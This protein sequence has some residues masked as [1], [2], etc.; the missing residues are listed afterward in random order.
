LHERPSSGA[1]EN[2]RQDD[3]QE[4][5]PRPDSCP[6][7]SGIEHISIH[8]SN[9][10]YSPQSRNR[11]SISSG[12]AKEHDRLLNDSTLDAD[13]RSDVQTPRSS[14]PAQATNQILPRHLSAVQARVKGTTPEKVHTIPQGPRH[15]SRY[16]IHKPQSGRVQAI[17][18]HASTAPSL[19][20]E[21]AAAPVHNGGPSDEDLLMLVMRRHRMRDEELVS[22]TNNHHRL[23]NEHAQLQSNYKVCHQKLQETTQQWHADVQ[24]YHV[25]TAQ[26]GAFRERYAKLKQWA[27][28]ASKDYD[29]L[30]AHGNKL[31]QDIHAIRN[32]ANNEAKERDTL[33]KDCDAAIG[34]IGA[35]KSNIT[36]LGAESLKLKSLEEQL[37]RET[38]RLREGNLRTKSHALYIERLE[39]TQQSMN[40]RFSIKQDEMAHELSKVVNF[41]KRQQDDGLSSTLAQV[42]ELVQQIH[43]NDGAGF[44]QNEELLKTL[45]SVEQQS[46]DLK[47]FLEAVKNTQIDQYA[48]SEW[49]F[50]SLV[51]AVDKLKPNL[52][53]MQT[54]EKESSTLC[55]KVKEAET[56]SRLADREKNVAHMHA[57]ALL[58]AHKELIR[59]QPEA[60]A[61]D[62]QIRASQ[63]YDTNVRLSIELQSNKKEVSNLQ[64]ELSKTRELAD[65]LRSSLDEQSDNHKAELERVREESSTR[66]SA[67]IIELEVQHNAKSA[68]VVAKQDELQKLSHTAEELRSTVRKSN[69]DNKELEQ[70]L[71]ERDNQLADKIE[72]L[73]RLLS[74]K[75]QLEQCLGP[76]EDMKGEIS[77]LQQKCQDYDSL[78]KQL[79][80]AQTDNS[81]IE[82]DLVQAKTHATDLKGDLK[83]ASQQLEA[84]Q[85]LSAETNDLRQTNAVQ[86]ARIK[87]LS[88]T[89]RYLEARTQELPALQKEI[90]HSNSRIRELGDK[91]EAATSVAAQVG[92]LKG[93]LESFQNQEDVLNTTRMDLKEKN[94]AVQDMLQQVSALKH[95]QSDFE[96]ARLELQQKDVEMAVMQDRINKLEEESRQFDLLR[97]HI[98]DE[99]IAAL[100]EPIILSFKSAIHQSQCP[101]EEADS[102]MRHDDGE[103]GFTRPK[104]AAN[105]GPCHDPAEAV[106]VPDSQSQARYLPNV[107]TSELSSPPDFLA[108]VPSMFGNNELPDIPID[109]SL[110]VGL[111]HLPPAPALQLGRD[112][113]QHRPGTSNEEMLLRSSDVAN[114]SPPGPEQN[115]ERSRA[116]A[117]VLVPASAHGASPMKTRTGTQIRHSRDST[118]VPRTDPG[119]GAVV[120][121]SSPHIHSR[122]P[123]APNSAAKRRAEAA[124]PTSKRH[125]VDMKRLATRSTSTP[126]TARFSDTDTIYDMPV[127]GRKIGTIASTSA[128]APGKNKRKTNTTLRKGSKNAQYGERFS[129]AESI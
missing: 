25:Q 12:S 22:L 1:D 114:F 8:S 83:E 4:E 32:A 43:Q 48:A 115:L 70:R 52:E 66:A 73:E 38:G 128:P 19:G 57:T 74:E 102:S 72:D 20:K 54:L 106:V 60:E 34:K 105:R 42:L 76:F 81:N 96:E 28:E 84:L 37:A 100:S 92:E 47:R 49:Q 86:L 9:S 129:Q 36:A 3:K 90:E 117:Q 107:D 10:Q 21:R 26:L 88:D 46:G 78:A 56:R 18:H 16:R 89:R 98:T 62:V 112:G 58:Q 80:Q 110:G 77:G 93:R 103:Y 5:L 85:P 51:D 101:D 94:R 116:R 82:R 111:G 17:I 125:K 11:D 95:I 53:R 63:L 65:T 23:Q 69:E 122:E 44:S 59:N 41:A 7:P 2:G 68:E 50:S 24:S 30:R 87:E 27:Q 15:D 124:E 29:S 64:S 99:E 31:G 33:L 79:K 123:H 14:P 35:V 13:E 75:H 97:E 71:R 113:L 55:A 45:T 126:K 40:T 39:R 67:R 127:S 6:R 119:S 108:D 91:L 121:F 118:P 104:R 109:A 61:K 120:N